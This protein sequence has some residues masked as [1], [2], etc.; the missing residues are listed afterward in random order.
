MTNPIILTLDVSATW[1][2]L[3]IA[4][5]MPKSTDLSSCSWLKQHQKTTILGKP[6]AINLEFGDGWNPGHKNC[7]DRDLDGDGHFAPWSL[8]QGLQDLPQQALGLARHPGAFGKNLAAQLKLA[9]LGY[10]AQPN[11]D[12][13]SN[14]IQPS[15]SI[16][17]TKLI[18]CFFLGCKFCTDCE[19][20]IQPACASYSCGSVLRNQYVF[21]NFVASWWR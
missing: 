21:E 9:A 17:W 19:P 11:W 8:H 10:E 13:L 15:K 16:Q 18:I 14:H 4:Q 3:K 6:N 7:D 20:H 5:N 1:F 12:S 2:P